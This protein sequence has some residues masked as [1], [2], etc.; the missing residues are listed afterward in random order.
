LRRIPTVLKAIVKRRPWAFGPV[1]R[2]DFAKGTDS[3]G[4]RLNA[5]RNFTVKRIRRGSPSLPV[6]MLPK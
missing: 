1:W 6:R 5:R 3:L 2:D 4:R